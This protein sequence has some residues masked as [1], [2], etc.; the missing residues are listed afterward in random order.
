MK[1]CFRGNKQAKHIINR[2]LDVYY[3]V[4]IDASM[5]IQQLIPSTPKDISLRQKRKK[6]RLQ[7]CF[8]LVCILASPAFIGE[9]SLAGSREQV[10]RTH[11]FF[12]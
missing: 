1:R 5:S 8:D 6:E 3:A 7:K 10:Y 2:C 12:L 9:Q 4:L 11:R